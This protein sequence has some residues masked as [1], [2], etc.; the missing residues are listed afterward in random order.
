MGPLGIKS[1]N[2]SEII[3][4]YMMRQ[5]LE[6]YLKLARRKTFLFAALYNDNSTSGLEP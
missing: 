2:I 5:N 1:S 4:D 3:L 6:K